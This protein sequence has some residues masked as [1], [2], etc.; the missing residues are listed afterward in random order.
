MY[1]I[2]TDSDVTQEEGNYDHIFSLALAGSN[3]FKVWSDGRANSVIGSHVEGVLSRDPL[4]QFALRN[5]GV[6]GHRKKKVV[7]RWK[8]VTMD[9][10]PIQV[11]WGMD[12]VQY[13]DAKQRRKME[14]EEFAGKKFEATL[15]FK[16][17]SSYRFVAKVAL[18]GGYFLYGNHIR[19]AIDCDILRSL[20]FSEFE[21]IK[22]E[23]ALKDSGIRICDRF[24]PDSNIDAPGGLYRAICE[25]IRRS[26]FISVPHQDAIS[27]HVGVTGMFI[28]TIIVPA[29]TDRL[30]IDGEHDLGHAIILGPGSMQ[31]LSFRKLAQDFKRAIESD[32]L[33]DID[34]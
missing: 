6:R 27:F 19:E 23:K 9:G 13:W 28:G 20:I 34:T 30:P 31:R 32:A 16:L 18:G 4:V 1:C 24:H 33:T 3:Q 22:Q 8:K 25:N 14:K 15:D 11:A 29:K 7:P 12:E 17:D 10:N 21:V 26:I 5:S 2:Y